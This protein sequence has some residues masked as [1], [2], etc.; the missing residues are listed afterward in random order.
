MTPAPLLVFDFDGVL[1]DGMAEYWWSARRAA[2]ALQPQVPLPAMAPPGFALLRPLI[3]KGWEMVLA[4]LELSR[5]DLDL[6][7]YLAHYRLQ[8]Q[9]AL[10]RWQLAPESLQRALET[11]RHQA[12]DQDRA[13]WLALHQPY[14]GVVK[15]L[16]QLAAE[17]SDWIVLTTKGRSFACELLRAH[18]LEPR[19]VYGHEQG[20]KPEVL[21]RLAQER[22]DG[23][24]WFV[25]DRRATLE[26]VRA[27]PGLESVRC[28]LVSWGYLGPE[29]R[30]G[31]PRGIVLLEPDRFA[32]PLAS[33]P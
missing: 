17:G 10:E 22:P 31:L 5:P 33:W 6:P 12:L 27:T 29:D 9:A 20:S 1:V 14:P 11:G 19:A 25:E 2:L 28:L 18:G 26:Q 13:A 23:P 21:L 32:A 16:A 7:A 15:R 8:L 30:Q 3:H 4:A 24:L